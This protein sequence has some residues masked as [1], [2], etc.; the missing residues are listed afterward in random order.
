VVLLRG[1][2]LEPRRPDHLQPE[3]A[4]ERDREGERE[5]GEQEPDPAVR[6]AG[7]HA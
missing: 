3:R 5:E 2:A 6:Q 4:H 1:Q 7:V